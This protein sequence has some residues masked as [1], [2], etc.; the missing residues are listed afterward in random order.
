MFAQIS[1][2]LMGILISQR[3][4]LKVPVQNIAKIVS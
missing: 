4:T 1:F 2:L 3:V